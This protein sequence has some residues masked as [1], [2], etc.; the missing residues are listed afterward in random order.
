MSLA[1]VKTDKEIIQYCG[2]SVGN[3]SYVI[4][5]LDVQEIIRPHNLTKVPLSESYVH[6]LI[7]LRGQ[8]VTS[9]SLRE[10]FGLDNKYETYMNVIVQHEG[11]LVALMVDKIRDVMD[12]SVDSYEPTPDTLD[13]KL[14]KYVKGVHKLENELFIVLDLDKIINC[15]TE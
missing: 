10:L 15:K 11:A 5:V 1:I 6:G 8:I 7:N 3:E 13:P 2:F 12:L 9:I 4:S 14:K